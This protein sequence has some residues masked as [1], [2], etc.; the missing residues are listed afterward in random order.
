MLCS[1]GSDKQLTTHWNIKEWVQNQW[2]VNMLFQHQS[3]PKC[4][5]FLMIQKKKIPPH[6][7]RDKKKVIS[8]MMILREFKKNFS[9]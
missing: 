7:H 6:K 1:N 2:E 8:Q 4:G 9:T 5:A 3:V